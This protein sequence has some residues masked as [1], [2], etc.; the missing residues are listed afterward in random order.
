MLVNEAISGRRTNLRIDHTRAVAPSVVADLIELATWAPNHHLTQPWRF[1]VITG[2]ARSRLGELTAAF[3]G[4]Q[5]ETNEAKLDKTRGKFLRA[6]VMMMIG[7]Q[8]SPTASIGQRL[9]DRD[10]CAA[11]VQNVL[12]GATAV[13][14]NSYWGSG[15]VCSAPAV[16]EM[17]GFEDTTIIAAIYLGYPIGEV[18][19]PSR[20]PAFVSWI[21]E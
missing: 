8:S 9:E 3:Q 6:P 11:A 17:C 7:C 2:E 5:G 21:D 16:H 13:G 1:A 14:L 15:P 18:P 4:A 12:L 19:I 20:K 10:A